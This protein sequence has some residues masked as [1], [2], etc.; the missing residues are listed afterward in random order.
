M[1]YRLATPAVS[2][3]IIIFLST[4]CDFFQGANAFYVI[5]SILNLQTQARAISK[6]C[7][8]RNTKKHLVRVLLKI[9]FELRATP[10]FKQIKDLLEP[11]LSS[12]MPLLDKRSFNKSLLCKK[13]KLKICQKEK[14]GRSSLAIS[15]K[16][17]K[18]PSAMIL[19]QHGSSKSFLAKSLTS[20]CL[21]SEAKKQRHE[22]KAIRQL[23]VKDNQ[24]F[25]LM[26]FYGKTN[27]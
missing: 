13:E 12:T 22:P 14:Q 15:S 2:F 23:S 17:I 19:C 5:P 18:L 1:P 26:R 8:A 21:P 4:S 6:K 10:N 20:S 3:T 27:M 7:F 9:A 24:I 25:C 11:C 16:G